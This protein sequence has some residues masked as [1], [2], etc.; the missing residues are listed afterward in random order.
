MLPKRNGFLRGLLGLWLQCLGLISTSSA[1]VAAPAVPLVR[2]EFQRPEMGLPFR[3]V[4]YAPSLDVATN[5]AEAAFARIAALNDCLSDYDERSELSR[6][7]QSSGGAAAH[8][9]SQDLWRVLK[10]AEDISCASDG[11]FD[12]TV[13]PLVQLWK[14]ARRQREL[15]TPERL[16]E[17]RTRVDWRAVVLDE[18]E[19]RTQKGHSARLTRPGMRLD[20]GGIAKGYALQEAARVLDGRG[21]HPFLVSGGGDMVA[22]E[23]PPGRPGWRIRIGAFDTPGG[24]PPCYVCLRRQALCTSGDQF[25]RAE[26]GG[27]R[28]SHIVDPRTG[29]ALT[30]HSLVTLIGPDGMTSDAL[31]KVVSVL[32]PVEGI[33]RLHQFHGTEC[34]VYRQPGQ[35]VEVYMSHDLHR[36]LWKPSDPIPSD[37]PEP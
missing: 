20:P 25:Q 28:Y 4:L 18:R 32:G 17:A 33:R 15:P 35:N 27:V 29:Q 37:S 19:A 12:I 34:L 13:G 31:S 2:F 10:R 1:L 30:D 7:S 16:A 3:I 21:I 22:G 14:R 8:P 23:P 9:V 6:L 24:P 26:I 5:A 36:W 11:T